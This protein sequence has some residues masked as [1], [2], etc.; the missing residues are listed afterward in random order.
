M[1]DW[2]KIKD[3]VNE[4]RLVSLPWWLRYPIG[5]VAVPAIAIGLV[6]FHGANPRFP[7]WAIWLAGAFF[8]IWALSAIWELA[9]IAAVCGGIWWAYESLTKQEWG[10]A[11]IVIWLFCLQIR[12]G[13]QADTIKR[14]E[15]QIEAM[16]MRIGL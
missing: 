15:S 9:I 1:A 8:E 10:I 14:L 6:W 13:V 12:T 2:A 5:L 3:D 11:V 4:L 16:R 7:E